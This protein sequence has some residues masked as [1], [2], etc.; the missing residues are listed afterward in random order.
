MRDE[1]PTQRVADELRVEF[2]RR[3]MNHTDIAN[4][5]GS[6]TSAVSRRLNGDVAFSVNDLYAYAAAAS[7]VVRIDLEPITD[8]VAA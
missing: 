5:V 6:S 3:N 7:L 8:Q 2:F 1:T 4:A